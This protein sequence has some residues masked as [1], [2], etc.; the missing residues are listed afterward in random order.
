MNKV[1]FK[2]VTIFFTFAFL[3]S[4]FKNTQTDGLKPRKNV[5]IEFTDEEAMVHQVILKNGKF[6][7]VFSEKQN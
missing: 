7:A 5:S 3:S 2:M 6:E 1:I 4:C